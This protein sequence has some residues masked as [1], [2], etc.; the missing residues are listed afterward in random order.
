[1]PTYR[2]DLEYDGTR[3]HGWQEQKNSR[4]VAGELKHA[5]A[6][7]GADVV[8]LGGAGRTD[9]GVSA[10]HQVAHL[11]TRA[12]VDP[13]RLRRD[14]NDAL[15]HD[16]HILAL[17]EAPDRFH[18][19]HDAALR[20]Y[21]YQI[22]RRRTA[23]AKRGVWWI[24][25]PLDVGAIVEA[26]ALLPGRHDFRV[27]CERPQDQAS[28]IVVVERAEVVEAGAL[29]LVRLAASHFLWK[30][31]RRLTGALVKVG[32][33]ELTRDAFR[34]LVEGG[35]TP[36]ES[37]AAWTAPPSGLFL[38]R[39]V[40]PGEDGLGPLVPAIPVPAEP[41]PRGIIAPWR[42]DASP[43]SSSRTRSRKPD[44]RRVRSRST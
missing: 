14:T 21:L 13:E 4:S 32:A 36:A 28:T 31:V 16:V 9:A 34:E 17:A 42:R 38:E 43:K 20:S 2:L 10:L 5:L 24:K 7:A 44:G 39:V 15:P 23:L 41:A 33:G 12:R 6:K 27:F 22:S 30:M 29:V 1:M 25:R 3:Y 35:A 26:A 19:R 18:A 8:E 11:R 40:Y 37:P